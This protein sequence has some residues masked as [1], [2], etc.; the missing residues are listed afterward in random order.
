MIQDVSEPPSEPA[1]EPV[2]RQFDER[3]WAQ[4][5]QGLHGVVSSTW[6]TATTAQGYS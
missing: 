4:F 6:R 3:L 5:H 2:D 1:P